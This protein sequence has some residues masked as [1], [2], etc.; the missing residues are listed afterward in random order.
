MSELTDRYN[1]ENKIAGRTAGSTLYLVH[2]RSRSGDLHEV[3]DEEQQYKL[4]L[5]HALAFVLL[6]LEPIHVDVK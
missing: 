2:A 3:A 4:F 1:V 5:A 6:F